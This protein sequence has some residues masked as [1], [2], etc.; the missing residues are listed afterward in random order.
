MGAASARGSRA[1]HGGSV[2]IKV[3]E[4]IGLKN[5]EIQR[6]M[7]KVITTL[8]INVSMQLIKN[9]LLIRMRITRQSG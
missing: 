9:Y 4:V 6:Q 8:A 1:S 5:M 2:Y 7:S 3:Y